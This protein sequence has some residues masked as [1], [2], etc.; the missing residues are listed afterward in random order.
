M[1]ISH[2][3]ARTAAPLVDGGSRNVLLIVSAAM[4]FVVLNAT[5]LNVALP[6]IGEDLGLEPGLLGWILTIYLLVYGVAIP[7]FGSF[8]DVCG[9][10]RFFIAGLAVYAL[11]SLL[12]A[13]ATSGTLLLAARV[14]QAVGGAAISGLGFALVASA[15]RPERRGFAFGVVGTSMGAASIAGATLAG[16]LADGPGWPA[17]FAVAALA[18]LLVP[19]A[20]TTLPV[21]V[22]RGGEHPDLRGGLFLALAIGGALFAATEGAQAGLGEARVGLAAAV[23]VGGLVGLVIRQRAVRSPSNPRDLVENRRYLALAATSLLAVAV[24]SGVYV[25]MPLLLS[26][27]NELPPTQIGLVLMPGALLATSLGVLI[28]RLVDRVGTRLPVRV[29]LV[30][31]LAATLGLSTAVGTSVWALAALMCLVELGSASV[32]TALATA[33]SLVVRP[34]RLPSAQSINAMLLS[35]GGS[36]GT[37]L[38]TA[39]VAARGG[40]LDALNPLHAGPGVP[41]SDG[42]LLLAVLPIAALAIS[43]PVLIGKTRVQPGADRPDPAAR[44]AVGVASR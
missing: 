27:V 8:A 41:F 32:S 43:A 40:A 42:F 11:G 31:L 12:C 18:G 37:T 16:V 22:G 9:A 14:V 23:A 29:G 4:I 2:D 24:T 1:S 39:V 21:D 6:T 17:V 34:E 20:W 44:S 7:L 5:G 13:V 30:A 38:S 36:L 33:I 19:L 3:R 10:R 26:A 25:G 15:V 28:G 35:L